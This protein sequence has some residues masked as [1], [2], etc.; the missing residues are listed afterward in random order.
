MSYF[1]RTKYVFVFTLFS[2]INMNEIINQGWFRMYPEAGLVPEAPG[3]P[4]P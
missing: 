1:V 3:A 2:L 4:F